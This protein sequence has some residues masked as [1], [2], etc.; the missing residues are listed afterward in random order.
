MDR[1]SPV[2]LRCSAGSCVLFSVSLCLSVCLSVWSA[3]DRSSPVYLRCSAG[4][5]VSFSVSLCLSVC[6]ALSS[7][8][9]LSVCLSQSWSLQFWL[10]SCPSV[11]YVACVVCDKT[12]GPP[13]DIL[14]HERSVD[15]FC[16]DANNVSRRCPL[17]L[18]I[19]VRNNLT[20]QI[21]RLLY[22]YSASV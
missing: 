21:C 13:V 5:C 6:L 16:S 19:S 17:W 2:Y 12:K 4:S 18:K 9:C 11:L 20:L 10:S 22:V 1:S 7:S 8:V 15:L 14:P 3:M